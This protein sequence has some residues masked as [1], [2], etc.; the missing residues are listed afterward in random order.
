MRIGSYG[1]GT[2]GEPRKVRAAPGGEV[3]RNGHRYGG[4]QF[5]PSTDA[6]PGTFRVGDGR[7]SRLVAASSGLVSPGLREPQPTP[8][9]RA[10]F[11]IVRVI[12]TFDADGRLVVDPARP[13][14]A[15]ETYG[16]GIRPGANGR[17]TDR[18][19][20]VEELCEIYNSGAR[21]IDVAAS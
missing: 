5:L 7:R 18:S 14:V 17:V 9:S 1:E 12:T 21:W 11:E 10:I 2:G 20:D 8:Y 16:R 3:G 4:G 19:Y 13:A 6:P 15:I